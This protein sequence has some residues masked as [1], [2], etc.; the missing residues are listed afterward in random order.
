MLV[1]ESLGVETFVLSN[2]VPFN[3]GTTNLDFETPH[4]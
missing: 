1:M 2:K 4:V 3:T